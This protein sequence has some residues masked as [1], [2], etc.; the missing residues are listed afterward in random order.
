MKVFISDGDS[1]RHALAEIIAQRFPEQLSAA[2]HCR[3]F[4]VRPSS[5]F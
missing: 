2:F 5:D 4:G 3:G 1:T